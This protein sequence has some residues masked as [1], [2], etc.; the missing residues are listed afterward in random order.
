MRVFK[1]TAKSAV[2]L[3]SGMKYLQGGWGVKALTGKV[4][5]ALVSRIGSHFV[6][7]IIPKCIPPERRLFLLNIHFRE[8]TNV[9]WNII[10]KGAE[11]SHDVHDQNSEA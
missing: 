8:S 3:P 11:G 4:A 9:L 7:S 2:N 1:N 5:D 6:V 10:T